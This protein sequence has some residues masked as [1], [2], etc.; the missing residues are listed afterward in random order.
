MPTNAY[1]CF[2]IR[3]GL[4]GHI[5]ASFTLVA[6]QFFYMYLPIFYQSIA[7]I[8]LRLHV[9][10]PQVL[11]KKN[12]GYGASKVFQS[13]MTQVGSLNGR[14]FGAYPNNAPP[15]KSCAYK[16]GVAGLAQRYGY[17]DWRG[18]VVDDEPKKQ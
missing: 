1:Y 18:H 11:H 16:G 14:M 6:V 8:L 9:F 15:I 4:R 10:N 12:G 2:V 3:R 13:I 7:S 17:G 5:L